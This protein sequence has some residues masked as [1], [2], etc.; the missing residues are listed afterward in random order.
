MDVVIRPEDIEAVAPEDGHI[1]GIVTSVT[2]K[3]VHNETIIDV[4]GFKWMMQTTKYLHEN[5]KIGMLL[6][7]DDIHIMKKSDYSG[8]F[9]DYSAFSDE[10]YE[11]Q[12]KKPER[13]K[14]R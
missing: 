10:I 4:N 9:G 3:G 6:E 11:E 7:P 12:A 2:F 14:E 5:E 13:V 1:S 8:E